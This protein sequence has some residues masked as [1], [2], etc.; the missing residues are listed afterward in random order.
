M[1][2]VAANKTISAL[3]SFIQV[4][5]EVDAEPDDHSVCE[6]VKYDDGLPREHWLDADAAKPQAER[7]Y[8]KSNCSLIE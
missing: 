8:R 2:V 6:I 1:N 7:N 4:A 3:V 5:L